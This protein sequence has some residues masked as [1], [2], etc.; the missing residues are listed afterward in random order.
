MKMS[1]YRHSWA[2][3][4]GIALLSACSGN[5]PTNDGAAAH[6]DVVTGADAK[7]VTQAAGEGFA[8]GESLAFEWS[9]NGFRQLPDQYIWAGSGR[10]D[11]GFQPHLSLSVPETDDVVWSSEC[12]AGGNIKSHIY[13]AAPEPTK[14]NRVRFRFETEKSTRTMEYQAQISNGQFDG[15]ELVLNPN[16]PMFAE[17]QTATW[18]YM[19]VG[20]GEK[21]SKL[22]VSLRRAAQSLASFLP[23]CSASPKPKVIAAA[24]PAPAVVRYACEGGRKVRATYLGNDTDTP[25]VRLEIDGAAYLLPQAIS[26]SGARYE[27]S[28]D[29]MADKRRS[30]YTKGK[31]AVFTESAWSEVDDE[32][33]LRC[34]EP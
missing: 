30:W 16:D 10:R 8:P 6:D 20:E 12:A 17:M 4:A 5:Q 26:G 2:A 25:S 11:A 33:V 13:L 3:S 22:R 15:V 1:L 28:Q 34:L 21:A 27:S 24:V 14:A 32:T 19:Q 29:K 9:A 18:A 31:D 7:P 23:A